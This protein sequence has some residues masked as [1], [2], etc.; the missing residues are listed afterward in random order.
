MANPRQSRCIKSK[1][2]GFSCA[3]IKKTPIGSI[4]DKAQWARLSSQGSK[5]IGN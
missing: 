2:L 1:L 3:K 5:H 4:T